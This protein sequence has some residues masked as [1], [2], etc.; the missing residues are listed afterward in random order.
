MSDL[1]SSTVRLK[2][3]ALREYL[4]DSYPVDG[5]TPHRHQWALHDALTTGVPGVFVN[6][7]PTG[8]G[9]TLSWLA[10][11]ISEGL[12]TVAVY[13]TNALIEDQQANIESQLDDIDGGDDVHLLAVSS[14]TLQDEY[15]IE[16]PAA[17]SNGELLSYLL[18]DAFQRPETVIL[19]TNPDI[20]VLLRREIYHKRIDGI[21]LFEVAVVDEFHRATRKEQN[22]LLFLL[23]EMQ[24]VDTEICRLSYLVFLSATPDEELAERFDEAV[25][26]PYYPLTDFGWR[27]TPHP[28]MAAD[29]KPAMAFAPGQLP[30]EYRPVL[31]PLELQLE[32]AATFQTA[33]RLAEQREETID[34]LSQGRTVLMLDGIHEVDEIYRLLQDS[35]L[36][37]IERIDGFHRGD[38]ADKLDR[39]DTLVSNAAVEVGVDFDTDQV[40]FSAHSAATFFQRLGRLRTREEISNAYAYLP[41]YVHKQLQPEIDEFGNDWIGRDRFEELVE[42]HYVD[43]ST[44]KSFDWRYSAV[45]AYHHVEKRVE[46]APTDEAGLIRKEG[47][48][49]IERHFCRPHGTVFSKQDAERCHDAVQ[50]KILDTLQMYR[51]NSLQLSVYDPD[52]QVIQN[53]NLTYLLRHG[54]IRLLERDDFFTH[55]PDHLEDDLSRVERY[56]IGYCIYYGT[57][58]GDGTED[59]EEYTG[60]DLCFKPTGELYSLLSGGQRQTRKPKVCTGLEVETSPD[61]DGLDQLKINLSETEILC[62]PIEGHVSEISKQYSIGEF[63]FV[64]PLLYS[65]GDTAAIAFSH[66]ALYLHCRVQDQQDDD[67]LDIELGEL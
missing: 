58:D 4:G 10:P 41:P 28:A 45:E 23:D 36:G 11:T 29:D 3:L 27:E 8:A 52:Q 34:R 17:E 63:G 2:G 12:D 57:Y 55:I 14:D 53:Y 54:D 48:K 65:E 18:R 64:Y 39:F 40:L 62:Y 59:D 44:P 15:A 60:R 6:D 42:Q 35:E 47:W 24:D 43:N 46:N 50:T 9:K 1:S 67:G 66:D 38:I 61:I 7:A 21:N 31:P 32:P 37:S 51:G 26:A 20:F 49:R 19:L 22:T 30:T 16:Y 33:T 5:V 13:P 25:S 56:S